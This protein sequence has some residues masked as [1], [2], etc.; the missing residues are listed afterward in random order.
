MDEEDETVGLVVVEIIRLSELAVVR[1]D[2]LC[3]MLALPFSFIV[4]VATA[5][6]SVL[7]LL[8][9][10]M[11]TSPSLLRKLL[12]HD[13]S[14]I[15]AASPPLN[16]N[17]SFSSPKLVTL[18]MLVCELLAALFDDDALPSDC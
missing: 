15:P 11:V 9:S 6:Y 5:A 16:L 13:V 8:L 4:V 2:S 17:G 12:L 1:L 18:F 14:T 7:V 10:I 3:F